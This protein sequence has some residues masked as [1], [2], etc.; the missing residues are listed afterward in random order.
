MTDSPLDTYVSELAATLGR[1]NVTALVL[2]ENGDN[3]LG[4]PYRGHPG[5]RVWD[6]NLT[7]VGH[8]PLGAF[9]LEADAILPNHVT[10]EVADHRYAHLDDQGTWTRCPA[11]ADG[12]VPITVA[13]AKIHGH[14]KENDRG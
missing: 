13:L 8:H 2:A 9:A 5:F 10:V 14:D 6:G 11:N 1:S 4:R 12:A 7:A 3:Q